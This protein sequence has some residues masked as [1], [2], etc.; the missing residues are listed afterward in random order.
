MAGITLDQANAQ[1]ASYLAAETAVLG[2]QEYKIA[3]R[4]M[5][6]ADL[7]Q[8]RDGIDYW[9]NKVRLLNQNALGRGRSRTICPGW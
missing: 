2:G 6:R 7:Q 8:I 1:L 5:K 4:M 9:N 3:G